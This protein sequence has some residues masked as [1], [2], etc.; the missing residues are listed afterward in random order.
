MKLFLFLTLNQ[1]DFPFLIMFKMI[2]Q[3]MT[4][5]NDRIREN[6]SKGENDVCDDVESSINQVSLDIFARL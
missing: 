5:M 1:N 3:I 2:G 6:G 4:S